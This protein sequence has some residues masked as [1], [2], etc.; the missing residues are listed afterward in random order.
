MSIQDLHAPGSRKFSPLISRYAADFENRSLPAERPNR[1]AA[2]RAVADAAP[3]LRI[4]LPLICALEFLVVCTADQDWTGD[5]PPIAWPSNEHLG[6]RLQ[7]SPTALKLTIRRLQ[8]FGLVVMRDSPNGKRFGR[9]DA[10]G[11]IVE[12]FGFDLSPLLHRH[13]EF[14]RVAAEGAARRREIVRLH[15]QAVSARRRIMQTLDMLAEAGTPLDDLAKSATE[16]RALSAQ[17]TMAKRADRLDALIEALARLEQLKTGTVKL[18]EALHGAAKP[19]TL[20]EETVWKR[21]N[22]DPK[23]SENGPHIDTQITSLNSSEMNTGR[24]DFQDKGNAK[25]PQKAQERPLGR[26]VPSPRPVDQIEPRPVSRIPD[27]LYPDELIALCPALQNFVPD[28]AASFGDLR[29]GASALAAE[30]GVSPHG[31]QRACANLSLVVAIA[32][33][34]LAANK[35]DD[36]LHTTKAH[37]FMGL[38]K[39]GEAGGLDLE[40]SFRFM[41]FKLKK[42]QGAFG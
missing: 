3:H 28:H 6:K 33:V 39:R 18:A 35:P 29:T 27:G 21:S 42:S 26:R 10:H 34:V 16:A 2:L 12:A 36:E 17:A 7:V 4:P 30:M 20:D 5:A 8:E 41:R 24:R 38:V 19:L 22:S 13:E 14:R 40:T 31:W 9:R 25:P 32:C 11:Q 15:R 1:F 37:Y 23:G